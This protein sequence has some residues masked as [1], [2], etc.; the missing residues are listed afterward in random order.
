MQRAAESCDSTEDHSRWLLGK[1]RARKTPGLVVQVIPYSFSGGE[2]SG[3]RIDGER[4]TING[5]PNRQTLAV[6]VP[7]RDV[8]CEEILADQVKRGGCRASPPRPLCE[9]SARLQAGLGPCDRGDNQPAEQGKS[10]QEFQ[11][12]QTAPIHGGVFSLSVRAHRDTATPSASN[13]SHRWSARSRSPLGRAARTLTTTV[14][15]DPPTLID[16][17]ADLF[18]SALGSSPKDVGSATTRS[19]ADANSST[20]SSSP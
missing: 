15:T 19:A 8:A 3:S 7:L 14:P 11:Q 13:T 1:Q 9:F 17:A 4:V 12:G 16:V 18:H 6:E 20:L 5:D 10:E 2:R